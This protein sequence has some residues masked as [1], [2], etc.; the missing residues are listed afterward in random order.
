MSGE[1]PITVDVVMA[2]PRRFEAVTLA[3]APGSTIADAVLAAGLPGTDSVTGYA[4]HGLASQASTL[5][6]DRDRVE[7]LR[8][9]QMDPK[10]AR[11]RRAAKKAG[12]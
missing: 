12:S 2:W 11:R 3:L 8:P 9:L 10:E 1:S 7:L 4:I 6:A 5:L